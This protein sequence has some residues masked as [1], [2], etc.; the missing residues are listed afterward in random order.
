MCLVSPRLFT[1]SRFSLD[2][3]PS[4]PHA[5]TYLI[6]A[7]HLIAAVIVS[8]CSRLHYNYL[9]GE[10][11]SFL[12]GLPKLT[13]LVAYYNYFIGTVPAL[14]PWLLSLDVRGNILTDLPTASYT[15]CGCAGNCMAAVTAAAKCISGGSGQRPAADCAPC[16]T[17]NAVGPFCTAGGVCTVDASARISAGTVNLPAQ[18]AL[19]MTCSLLMD[20]IVRA[21]HRSP[22]HAP[23]LVLLTPCSSP[24]A[25]HPVLLTPCSS[26]RAPHPVLL[27]P[28]SSPRAPHPVLLT[29]CS[30]PRAPHPVLLTPCSSPRA[31]HPVLL[32]PCSSPRAPHPVPLTPCPS[33]RAPHPVLL[34]VLL[35]PCPSPVLL[36]VLLTPCPS[37]HAP[38]PVLLT[39]CSSPRAPHRA[40]HRTPHRTPHRALP[41]HPST[42]P[43]TTLRA[44]PHSS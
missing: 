36:T 19:P 3:P 39:L 30:S 34:T 26:P 21:P 40:P 13:N 14:G 20:W 4:V 7:S 16:G 41:L 29:P 38:H 44:A 12:V 23:H 25:P 27:T 18:P 8:P 42:V 2:P 37:P 17:T 31:P 24:R 11:P 10:I 5:A 35:T 33:P 22:L 43:N 28:C 6:G 9:W 32:T 1:H 15:W